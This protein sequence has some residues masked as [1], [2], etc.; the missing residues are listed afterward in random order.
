MPDPTRR[1]VIVGGGFAGVA[2][3]RAL[4][5]SLPR[6]WEIV[7]YSRENHLVF[8]PLLAEVVGASISPIH[9]VW[10]IREMTPGLTCLTTSVTSFDTKARE[11]V[12][13]GARGETERLG[14]DHLVLAC[15]LPVRL[16]LV[17]GMA[18]FGWPLKTLGDAAALR[19][20][21]IAQLERAQIETDGQYKARLLSIAV[22][23]GG[24]TGVEVAGSI[25]DLLKE[26]SRYY[27]RI[28]SSEI[29]VTLVDGGPRI[30]GPLAESLSA[31]AERKMRQ[32]G[33]DIRTGVHVQQVTEKGIDLGGGDVVEAD[34]VISAVG[35]GI[36][37][38]V[39]GA[40]LP[41][42]RN[43]IVVTPEMRVEGYDDVWALGDCA[44]V[45]NAH[46]G[47]ISPTLAQF[48]TRQARQ[49]ARNL[50]AVITGRE[51]RPFRYSPEGLF[52]AIGH[53]NAVGQAFGIRL[54]GFP[55]WVLW[56]GIYWAKMPTLGRKI[57]VALDWAW[58]LFFPRDLVAL[59]MERT[60]ALEAPREEEPAGEGH[61]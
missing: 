10:A 54:S 18:R 36:H 61:S 46:D 5:R 38:L 21:L 47:S 50:T 32:R 13:E 27:A 51:P 43:R 53:R 35:N 39:A 40:G 22:V 30:L 33:V 34:T 37:A 20:H 24:F 7:L 17:P 56:H 26:A 16:D 44:A 52:A 6:G 8:T 45:P 19:N 31:F 1:I 2:L 60:K 28:D 42:E 48:A 57:Q 58:D 11:V 55:A 14:Y 25:I 41:L 3:A 23:G 15:G 29:R 59:P 49:L 4:R 9:V 12:Y